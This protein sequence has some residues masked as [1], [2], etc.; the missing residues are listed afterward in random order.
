MDTTLTAESVD[1]QKDSVTTGIPSEGNH[2]YKRTGEACYTIVGKNGKERDVNLKDARKLGLLPS[3]TGILQMEAK[4]Q[5]TAWLIDQALMAAITLPRIPNENLDDFKARASQDA[6]AQA[7]KARARGQVLH[8]E[9]ERYLKGEQV[10][11]ESM[12][13]VVPVAD[14]LDRNFGRI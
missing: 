11:I 4:P 9:I 6:G 10:D 2:W 1:Q 12:K 3:V 5:L 8:A 14:W 7:M 13:Y